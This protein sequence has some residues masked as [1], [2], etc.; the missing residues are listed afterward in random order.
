MTLT[1]RQIELYS[2]QI[3]LR[4]LGGTGQ[5]RLLA[6]SCIVL[7]NDSSASYVASYLAGAGVGRIDRAALGAGA[8]LASSALAPLE[9]TVT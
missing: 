2:R 9:H 3:I 8:S 1:D 6:S 7:G 5:R 4:E